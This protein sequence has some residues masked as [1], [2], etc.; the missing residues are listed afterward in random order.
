MKNF[1]YKNSFYALAL[2]LGLVTLS[3]QE[4]ETLARSVK[5]VVSLDYSGPNTI[6]EGDQVQFTLNVDKASQ[7]RI[8]F[9][10]SLEEGSTGSVSDIQH[11]GISDDFFA[12]DEFFAAFGLQ[13]AIAPYTTSQTFTLIANKDL[14]PEDTEKFKVRVSSISKGEGFIDDLMFEFNVDNYAQPNHDL[15]IELQWPDAASTNEEFAGCDIDF[16]LDLYDGFFG[17]YDNSWYDCPESI[18]IPEGAPDDT[19]YVV[20]SIYDLGGTPDTIEDMVNLPFRL[21][22]AKQ[23]I[24]YNEIDFNLDDFNSNSGTGAATLGAVLVKTGNTFELQNADGNTISTGKMAMPEF[25]SRRK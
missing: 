5:P 22:I 16:D 9:R 6:M 8:D 7:H 15:T 1:I 18:T 10:I 17:A 13:G 2:S 3:C 14:F 11:G 21:V 23:G 25:K 24:W 12:P 4:D 20:P 19:Y